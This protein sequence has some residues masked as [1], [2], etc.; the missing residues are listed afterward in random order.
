MGFIPGLA[1]SYDQS[2][3]EPDW[4]DD[5]K[6]P[7]RPLVFSPIFFHYSTSSFLPNIFPGFP[8]PIPGAVIFDIS[9]TTILMRL[10]SQTIASRR[11]PKSEKQNKHNFQ[12]LHILPGLSLYVID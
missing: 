7:Q 12:H 2:V 4:R 11:S 9:F 8:F 3:L 1:S 6:R 10:D 5:P